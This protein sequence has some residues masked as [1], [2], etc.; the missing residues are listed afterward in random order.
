MT[1][2]EKAE[3][4]DVIRQLTT[5]LRET[6]DENDR[7]RAELARQTEGASAYATLSDIHRNR[8]LPAAVRAKAAIGCIQHELPR[9]TPERAPLEL[10][11]VPSEQLADTVHRQRARMNQMLALP[12]EVRS[13]LSM[14]VVRND[15]NG[16]DDD[17][18]FG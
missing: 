9:L 14:G 3:Y 6:I 4:D 11:P 18:P 7:L 5:R 1:D 13:E 17:E 12:L 2:I 8:D 10:S 15:G 16:A